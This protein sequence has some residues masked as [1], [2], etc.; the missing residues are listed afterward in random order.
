MR[1]HMAYFV[2][3]GAMRM[4]VCFNVGLHEWVTEKLIE[5]FMFYQF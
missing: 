4:V 2:F 5:I 1:Q 3:C